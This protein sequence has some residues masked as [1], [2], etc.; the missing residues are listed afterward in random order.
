M[1]GCYVFVYLVLFFVILLLKI[2]KI[3][4]D[5]KNENNILGAQIHPYPSSHLSLGNAHHFKCSDK[6]CSKE[7]F[8]FI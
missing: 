4:N 7:T 5:F 8:Y 1:D 6:S 2:K 3:L